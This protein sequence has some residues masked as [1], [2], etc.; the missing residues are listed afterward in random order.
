L[1]QAQRSFERITHEEAKDI[2]KRYGGDPA[3]I[4]RQLRAAVATSGSRNLISRADAEPGISALTSS[5]RVETVLGSFLLLWWFAMVIC[6]GE[7]LEMDLQRRR[8]PMWE[9]LLSHP[10]GAGAVFFAEMLSP[11]FA[12]PTYWVAP[13]FVGILYGAAQNA[14]IGLA[15]TFLIGI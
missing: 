10:I 12:N 9:W 11:L 1:P 6:Q 2:A 8:H 3:E 14:L 5:G 13:L 15:A 4:E 7:G